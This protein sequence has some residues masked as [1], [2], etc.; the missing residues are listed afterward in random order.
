[1]V[2]LLYYKTYFWGF[3]EMVISLFVLILLDERHRKKLSV[4]LYLLREKNFIFWILNDFIV[5]LQFLCVIT[6]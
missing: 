1:M 2:N 6:K 3:V 5:V 4:V